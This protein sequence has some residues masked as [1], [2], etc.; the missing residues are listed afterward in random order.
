MAA[1]PPHNLILFVPDGLRAEVV[2]AATAPAMAKLRS[3]GVDFRNSHSLFPTLTTAN[4]SAFATGHKLADTGDFSNVIFTGFPVQAAGGS[5]T[6]F[7]ESDSVLREVNEHFNGNY[8]NEDSI[9]AS[10][11]RERHYS[12][13][14]VGKLG[15]VAVFDVSALEGTGTLVVDDATGTPGKE[16][17]LSPEWKDAFRKFRVSQTA[18]SR[19]DN[20]NFGN[21]ATPGTWIPNLAQQQYF[22]EVTV[23]AILPHF[24]ETGQ[25]FVLIF[26]SRDPDGTQHNH[27]DSFRSRNRGINGP[28][29]LS[30]IRNADTALAAIE[31]ALKALELDSTTNIIVAADHGFSSISKTSATS[32]STKPTTPYP[33]SEVKPGELPPGFLAIDLATALGTRNPALKLFDPDRGNQQLDWRAGEHPQRGNAVLG[34]DA[35]NP[36]IVIAANGGSDLIYIGGHMPNREARRVAQEIVSTLLEQD[37]VSGLFVEERRFGQMPG[38]LSTESIQVGGGSAITP[39]PDVVVGFNSRKIERCALAMSL[40][41][42][43]VAD[44]VLQE[45]QGMHGSLSRADTWNF[46]AARGPDFRQGYAD[47]LPASN[48]DIGVTIGELLGVALPKKGTHIGR[49]LQ[50]A[51]RTHSTAEVPPEAATRT[52]ESQ[53]G[54]NGLKTVLRIQTLG[55]QSYLDAGGFPG[56]TVGLDSLVK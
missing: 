11:V 26:W 41:A 17:P 4:A 5:V 55:S 43:E 9:I 34:P 18:P 32:P 38:A 12:A 3:D 19:G 48:A 54:P 49:V 1:G 15:P 52:L 51:L 39:R 45:G 30:A 56:R 16:V 40:C 29:S 7:L 46:M 28:T 23:K 20:A 42:E 25:P 6:P 21:A 36:E 14:L 50:E 35:A 53:P 31:E 44:T 47:E 13:A 10:A 27:G 24:K 22:L 2:D 33:Q 8:L 37:Y